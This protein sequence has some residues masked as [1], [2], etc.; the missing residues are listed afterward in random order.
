MEKEKGTTQ[1]EKKIVGEKNQNEEKGNHTVR[2]KEELESREERG[3][4]ST[5][6][7]IGVWGRG[8]G[9]IFL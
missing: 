7:S 6:Y 2:E 5:Y 9:D 3:E 4:L 8:E 1:K